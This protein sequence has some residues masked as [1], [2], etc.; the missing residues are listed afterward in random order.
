MVDSVMLRFFEGDTLRGNA[1]TAC[2]M[3]LP[4]S[5][6]GSGLV[7]TGRARLDRLGRGLRTARVDCIPFFLG[8]A[9]APAADPARARRIGIAADLLRF[10]RFGRCRCGYSFVRQKRGGKC[11]GRKNKQGR[12]WKS[13]HISLESGLEQTD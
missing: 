2:G 8:A 13:A 4:E 3:A 9:S 1:D 12:S 11:Q 10:G 6:A 5:Q 7:A